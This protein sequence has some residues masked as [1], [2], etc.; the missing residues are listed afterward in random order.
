MEETVATLGVGQRY[1]LCLEFF[2]FKNPKPG[3]PQELKV[4]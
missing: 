2:L 4:I 3:L 1:I